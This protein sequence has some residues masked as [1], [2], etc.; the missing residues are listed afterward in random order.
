MDAALRLFNGT[1]GDPGS[2]DRLNA[3]LDDQ[4]YRLAFWR[5]A[6]EEINYRRFFDVNELAGL[7]P[8]VPRVRTAS[9]AHQRLHGGRC[10]TSSFRGSARWA[11]SPASRRPGDVRTGRSEVLWAPRLSRGGVDRSVIHICRWRV[12]GLRIDHPDGLYEAGGEVRQPWT[13]RCASS[14]APW[15]IRDPLTG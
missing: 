9:S 2:F 5:V 15:A 4:P 10:A 11:A 13:P 14:T 8:E 3:L 1:V 12:S 6:A 7:R